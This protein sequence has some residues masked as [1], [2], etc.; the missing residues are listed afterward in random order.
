MPITIYRGHVRNGQ[1]ALDQPATLP[2]G[3]EV[4]VQ[5]MANDF[6]RRLAG[7]G[8]FQQRTHRGHRETRIEISR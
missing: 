3:A 5:Q 4:T 8:G 2:E 1:I 6:E 7:P